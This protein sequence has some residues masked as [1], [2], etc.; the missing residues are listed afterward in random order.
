MHALSG[1]IKHLYY[2]RKKSYEEIAELLG[3]S[4][5]D[6]TKS[7]FEDTFTNHNE[8]DSNNILQFPKTK[9]KPEDCDALSLLGFI[10][11]Y[12]NLEDIKKG[13]DLDDIESVKTLEIALY[14]IYN[15]IT[16]SKLKDIL[17]HRIT[18]IMELLISE[19]N[20]GSNS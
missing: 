7:L 15:G 10:V 3:I 12:N 9:I 18:M 1:K 5:N 6:V 8:D 2:D 4:V 17:A 19:T 11:F 13:L 20:D 16:D 14:T